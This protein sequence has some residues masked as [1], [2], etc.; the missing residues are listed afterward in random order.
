[1]ADFDRLDA[2]FKLPDLIW[3][4]LP[5][6]QD[7]SFAVFKLRVTER[8][9]VT[10]HPM[11]FEFVTRFRNALFFPTVH[12]HDGRVRDRA[13]FDHYLFYQ[14]ENICHPD[15]KIGKPRD[16]FVF[17][18]QDRAVRCVRV[19]KTKGIV[20]GEQ[21]C[22]VVAKYGMLPNQDTLL[23]RATTR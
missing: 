11:A 19:Q 9:G 2:R 3:D 17:T 16:R 6:Y 18:S 12:V 22:R 7:Y 8:D 4:N 20:D 13:E 23:V 10:V 15:E 14:G 5:Q 21:P 1:M